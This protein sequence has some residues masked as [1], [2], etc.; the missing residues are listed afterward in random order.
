MG[1]QLMSHDAEAARAAAIQEA[2]EA[3]VYKQAYMLY[4]FF[5]PPYGERRIDPVRD[6]DQLIQLRA[7]EELAPEACARAEADYR[8]AYGA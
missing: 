7:L 2:L 8:K 4:F 3:I 5:I 1:M 6:R